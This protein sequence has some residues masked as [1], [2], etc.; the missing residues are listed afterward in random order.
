MRSIGFDHVIDYE[1][2]DFTKT[3]KRYDLILDT[4]TNRSLAAYLRALTPGGTYVTVGGE[5]AALLRCLIFGGLIRLITGKKI[6]MIK[7]KQ[8]V[9]LADLKACFEAGGLAPVI[10]GPYQLPDWQNALRHFSA[11]DHKGKVILT[12]V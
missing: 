2:E 12:M 4:K 9:H 11:A 3:G 7:L 10:D 8:N 1:R 6:V 5:N